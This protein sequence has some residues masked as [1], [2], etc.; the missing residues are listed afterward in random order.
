MKR[1]FGTNP[2]TGK[3]VGERHRWPLGWGIDQ[4]KF[5]RRWKS[6][7]VEGAPTLNNRTHPQISSA[8]KAVA[9]DAVPS[10]VPSQ[11]DAGAGNG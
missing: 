1:C 8:S 9:G 2:R 5:C 3:P 7:L 11:G 10:A 6:D 4:C